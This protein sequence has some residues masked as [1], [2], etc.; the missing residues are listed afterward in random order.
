[1]F[2]IL[3]NDKILKASSAYL[4]PIV[5]I[6]TTVV[7]V[8]QVVLQR[9]QQKLEL[10]KLR[11][12][13]I[14]SIFNIWHTFNS[15]IYYVK[16]SKAILISKEK[17]QN[18]IIDMMNNSIEML[19]QHNLSTK[20]LFNKEIYELENSL[21]SLLPRFIPSK[22][23]MWTRYGLRIEEYMNAKKLFDNLLQ[24]FEDLMNE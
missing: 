11:M 8:L 20:S 10:F 15:N 12:E 4:T 13:H 14:K 21:I 22:G 17:E 16:N 19:N 1:M 5:A 3:L 9:K 24:K 23:S 18:N 6:C 2:D 7:I